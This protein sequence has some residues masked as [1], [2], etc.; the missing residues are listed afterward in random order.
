MELKTSA[1][2]LH[3]VKYTDTSLVATIYTRLQGRKSFLVQGVYKP[4]SKFPASYFQPLTLLDLEIS[5][6][7]RRELQRIRELAL[8]VPFHSVPF[9]ITRGT[10]ALFLAEILYKTLR[11]EEPNPVLFDFLFHAIQ[12]FDL[13]DEGAANFHLWFLI[14]FTKHLGFYPDNNF[15]SAHPV[16]DPMNGRFFSP[17][18]VQP[19]ERELQNGVWLSK[20]MEASLEEAG[21]LKLNH[22]IRNSLLMI[23]VEYYQVHLGGLGQIKSLPVLQNVFED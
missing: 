1:I 20:F 17:M 13:N 14:N 2:V 10:I 16:F 22:S 7:P 6:N 15:S 18:M 4:R 23:L 3:H 19:T 8:H 9:D 12:F 21:K 5:I 11:E